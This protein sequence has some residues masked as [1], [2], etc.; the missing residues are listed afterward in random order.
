MFKKKNLTPDYGNY[1][2]PQQQQHPKGSFMLKFIHILVLGL[3]LIN[4]NKRF[5][6]TI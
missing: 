6:Y 2:N 3:V 5:F 1:L 4:N